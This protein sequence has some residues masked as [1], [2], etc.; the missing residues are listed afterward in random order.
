MEGYEIGENYHKWASVA[1]RIYLKK[2]DDSMDQHPWAGGSGIFYKR[3]HSARTNSIVSTIS[4]DETISSRH[5]R[6]DRDA[7]YG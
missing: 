5:L 2:R 4:T 7:C 6:I 3:F 1:Y